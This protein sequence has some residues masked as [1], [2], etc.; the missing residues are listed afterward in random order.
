M[1]TCALNHVRTDNLVTRQIAGETIIVPVAGG[2]GQ[3]NAIFTLNA[4]GSMIWDMLRAAAPEHEILQSIC[5]K[6][7]VA[8]EQAQP[9]L[10]AFLDTLRAAGLLCSSPQTGG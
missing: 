2:A 1:S 3:L 10:T 6:Y 4:V 8:P 7:E 5:Q 9:D